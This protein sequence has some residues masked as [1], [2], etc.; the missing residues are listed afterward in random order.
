MLW[1]SGVLNVYAASE[2]FGLMGR[3]QRSKSWINKRF[4]LLD[5]C[6][7][8]G[9][10][11]VGDTANGFEQ[12]TTVRFHVTGFAE[13]LPKFW[14][15]CTANYHQWLCTTAHQAFLASLLDNC[16]RICTTFDA[17]GSRSHIAQPLSFVGCRR[18]SR[19]LLAATARNE[20]ASRI[21]EQP[22]GSHASAARHN[23][24]QATVLQRQLDAMAIS[25]RA[26]VV[27][28]TPQTGPVEIPTISI[29]ADVMIAGRTPA[30]N[31]TTKTKRRFFAPEK[32]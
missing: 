22:V 28:G 8:V 31:L 13:L 2:A 4:L 26:Y 24:G 3:W 18:T 9:R 6:H 5:A 27:V 19:D 25:E 29:E 17:Y 10:R 1:H 14:M 20:K 23:E 11:Y 15:F 21:A 16:R 32:G 7:E 30:F 12:E